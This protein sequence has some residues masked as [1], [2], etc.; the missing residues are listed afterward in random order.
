M[1]K[2]KFEDLII[3]ENEDYIAINKPPHVATLEDRASYTNILAM[4]REYCETAQNCHRLDKETSG[5]LMIAKTPDAYRHL[6]VQFEKRKVK[7]IYHA[8][9][10]GIHE[11]DQK[12]NTL[13]IYPGTKGIVKIDF[14]KGKPSHT[15]F[16]TL[17]AYKGHTLVEAIPHTG[18]MHQIRIH[19]STLKAPI[20]CDETYGG[21]PLLLS[22]LKRKFNLKKG[23][24]E[25]PLLKRFALH[26]FAIE[27]K[28]PKGKQMKISAPYPKDFAV[29]VKQL[30]KNRY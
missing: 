8:I 2:V 12:E 1:K 29:A 30:E 3:F 13:P 6:S 20:S 7:K 26:A 10:D 9:V 5:V 17:E 25:Q 21:S 19:L 16:N 18:R 15:T 11:F 4:A 14:E 22:Q 23:T 24:E 27:F 28:D